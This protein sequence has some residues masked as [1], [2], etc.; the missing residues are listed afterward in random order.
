MENLIVLLVVGLFVGS[1]AV[2][3]YKEKMMGA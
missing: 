1:S 3:I 2:Y